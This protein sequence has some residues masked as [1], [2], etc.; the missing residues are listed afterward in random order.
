[1]V[2]YLYFNCTFCSTI[3]RL[4]LQGPVAVQPV[5]PSAVAVQSVCC[6]YMVKIGVY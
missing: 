3:A 1:M 4:Q 2:A 5:Y 6:T